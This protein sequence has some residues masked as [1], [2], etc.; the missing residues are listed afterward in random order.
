MRKSILAAFA[1]IGLALAV[2]PPA[3][4]QWIYPPRYADYPLDAYGYPIRGP[5]GVRVYG[6]GSTYTYPYMYQSNN[7]SAV[8]WYYHN[9]YGPGISTRYWYD[10]RF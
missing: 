9:Y 8:P 6:P 7:P 2:S 4:A 5:L 3:T 10:R 1:A